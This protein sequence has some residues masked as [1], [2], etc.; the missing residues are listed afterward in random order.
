MLQR[1]C[2]QSLSRLRYLLEEDHPPIR[3]PNP[4]RQVYFN[5]VV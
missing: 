3:P 2:A 4:E 5:A 1:N